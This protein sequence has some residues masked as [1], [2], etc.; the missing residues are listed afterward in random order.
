MPSTQVLTPQERATIF[1]I[2]DM[3]IESIDQ[4]KE[5]IDKGQELRA[6]ELQDK[7][8]GLRQEKKAIRNMACLPASA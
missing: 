5:A 6:R 8:K 3:L 2:E 4:Y 1:D 7:I